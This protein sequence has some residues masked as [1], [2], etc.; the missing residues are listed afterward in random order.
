MKEQGKYRSIE[1]A[2]RRRGDSYKLPANFTAATMRRVAE[3]AAARE[4]RK[5]RIC[6]FA[7]VAA[8]LLLFAGCI[9]VVSAMMEN[10]TF[11][12]SDYIKSIKINIEILELYFPIFVAVI[13]LLMLDFK[14]RKIF[15]NKMET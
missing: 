2:M 6:L 10:S 7:T 12:L 14:L 11:S 9:K 1:N 13:L 3:A 8:S 15:K 4:R 5:N